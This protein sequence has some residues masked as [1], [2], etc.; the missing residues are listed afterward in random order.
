MTK[1]DIR[2]YLAEA[3]AEQLAGLQMV[4]AAVQA[5][6]AVWGRPRSVQEVA[7]TLYFRALDVELAM[8]LDSTN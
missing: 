7:A 2:A 3:S 8:E 5:H 6:L 4:R 1:A